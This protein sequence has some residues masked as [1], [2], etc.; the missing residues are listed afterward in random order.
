MRTEQHRTIGDIVAADYRAAAVFERYGLDFC[1]GGKQ[2]L[3]EAC[4]QPAV[5]AAAL[6]RELEALEAVPSGGDDAAALPV[7]QLADH[8]VSTHH[9]YVRSAI[10]ILEAHTSKIAAVHGS[11]SPELPEVASLVAAIAEEM[12]HHM[13]KEE[14]VLFPYIK[15][16]V[17]A[18]RSGAPRPF[19]PF[20]TVQNPIRMMELEHQSAGDE[21]RAIRELT[22]N[23][24]VPDFACA[25]YRACLLELQE[26]ETDLHRH[27]HL[28]NN[29]LFPRALEIESKL[30][31]GAIR[32]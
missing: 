14:Q 32:I 12:L 29:V 1:C 11:R 13:T 16:L 30:P 31:K 24:E 17:R 23:Y 28:E 8:I 9:A 15:A 6:M 27:V 19:M 21:M 20:G 10:P 7:D 18:E 2:T 22:R 26:F 4:R 25:T 5:D 3:E